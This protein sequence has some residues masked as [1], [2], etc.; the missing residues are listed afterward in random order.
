MYDDQLKRI[1]YI[2]YIKPGVHAA[3]VIKGR[4]A[5]VAG[6]SDITQ[7][8]ISCWS[9]GAKDLQIPK[10]GTEYRK[11]LITT[12][13]VDKDNLPSTVVV[14][15]ANVSERRRQER[16][17]GVGIRFLHNQHRTIRIRTVSLLSHVTQPNNKYINIKEDKKNTKHIVKL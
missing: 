13:K 17:R 12:I 4:V 2:Y 1:I 5:L 3:H 15:Y 9:Y 14:P 16:K 8:H 7:S 6:P 11:R 10:L